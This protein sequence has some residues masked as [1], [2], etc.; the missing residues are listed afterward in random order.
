MLMRLNSGSSVGAT[1]NEK[2]LYPRRA[3][4]DATRARTPGLFFTSTYNMWCVG[5]LPYGLALFIGG[6]PFVSF[7]S[8]ATRDRHC[9]DLLQPL[10]TLF[11]RH[12]LGSQQQLACH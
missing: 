9:F 1:A 3:N 4:S 8:D 11:R 2:M 10:E 5:A 7:D 6:T 12:Q